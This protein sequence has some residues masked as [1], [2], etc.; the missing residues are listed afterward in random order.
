MEKWS[1]GPYDTC[2]TDH[3]NEHQRFHFERYMK[4]GNMTLTHICPFKKGNYFYV[5]DMKVDISDEMP[6]RRNRISGSYRMDT[7]IMVEKDG[8][9]IEILDSQFYMTIE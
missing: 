2:E 7:K 5:R 8:Q 3:F 1:R 6:N 4:H 9:Q